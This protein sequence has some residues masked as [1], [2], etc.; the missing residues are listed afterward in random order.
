MTQKGTQMAKT[1]VKGSAKL[2]STNFGD[3]I[4]LGFKV[5]DLVAFV[6][7]H[8]NAK[9]YINLDVVQRKEVGQYG[10]THS[11]V[12]DDWQPGTGAGARADNDRHLGMTRASELMKGLRAVSQGD[13]FRGGPIDDSAV[14]F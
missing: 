13:G 11:I 2:R 5:E 7:E 4:K 6:R 14:P 10:D 12:L 9:G 3:V 8:A 1:Y